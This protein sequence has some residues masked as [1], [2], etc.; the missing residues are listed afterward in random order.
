[1][2]YILVV[3]GLCLICMPSGIHIR[4]GPRTCVTTITYIYIVHPVTASVLA[5]VIDRPVQPD[6]C[7]ILAVTQGIQALLDM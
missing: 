7:Y 4:Q 2:C 3:T 6:K 5:W 1:M